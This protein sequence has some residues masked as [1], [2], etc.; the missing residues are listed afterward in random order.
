[1]YTY[2]KLDFVWVHLSLGILM[3]LLS[4]SERVSGLFQL[5]FIPLQDLHKFVFQ[6][7]ISGQFITER[8]ALSN[9]LFHLYLQQSPVVQNN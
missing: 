4:I 2:K 6:L 8:Q 1:M 7:C 3:F 5:Q 9:N